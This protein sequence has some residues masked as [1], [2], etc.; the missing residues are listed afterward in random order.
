MSDIKEHKSAERQMR[1]LVAIIECSDD[2]IVR[3]TL[4]GIVTSWNKNPWMINRCRRVRAN[5]SVALGC[6]AR[7]CASSRAYWSAFSAEFAS[8][9]I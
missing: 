7:S 5:T 8:F 3:K 1:E 9:W 6:M 4:D 2:A